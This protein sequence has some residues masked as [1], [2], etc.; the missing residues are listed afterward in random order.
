M[1]RILYWRYKDSSCEEIKK[2]I[3]FLFH[4]HIQHMLRMC[5]IAIAKMQQNKRIIRIV[6]FDNGSDLEAEMGQSKIVVLPLK[7]FPNDLPILADEDF[8]P[9]P[10]SHTGSILS[11]TRASIVNRTRDL[12]RNVNNPESSPS[13]LPNATLREHRHSTKTWRQ[14]IEEMDEENSDDDYH[15]RMQPLFVL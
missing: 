5:G 15:L 6:S 14:R 11:P 13:T 2:S 8:V 3:I 1:K 9:R 4:S 7:D 12:A 10:S